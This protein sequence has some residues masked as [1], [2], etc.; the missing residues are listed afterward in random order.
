MHS[1]FSILYQK[2]IG[3]NCFACANIIIPE[4]WT[5]RQS[6]VAIDNSSSLMVTVDYFS[7]LNL[8]RDFSWPTIIWR[9]ISTGTVTLAP[10]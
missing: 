8:S 4:Q 10:G 7:T 3:C 2:N 9:T 5:C 1:K 6:A